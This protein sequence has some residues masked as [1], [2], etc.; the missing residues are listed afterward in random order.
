M[1]IDPLD[2][3]VA[4]MADELIAFRRDLHRHPELSWHEERTTEKLLER[5]KAAGLDPA[6]APTGTGVVCDLDTG[7]APDAPMVVLR[8]DIDALPLTDAKDVPYHSVNSGVCHACGHDVHTAAVLGAGL[9]LRAVSLS[10][11]VRLLFQPAEETLP[12][13]AH[14]LQQA[15]CT[16]GATAVLGL[17][18]A[19]MHEVGT[20]GLSPGPITSAADMI[21]ITLRGPGGHTG[22]PHRTADLVHLAARVVVDL[23]VGLGRLT[24]SRDGINVTFG[25]INAGHA[26]NVIPTEAQIHGTVR[27]LGRDTWERVPAL[28]PH[29]LRAIVEPFG[30]TFELEYQQGSPPVDND[31]ALTAL[32]AG[33]AAQILGPEAVLPTEQSG[34]GEDFSWFQLD[35]P[36]CYVRLGVRSPGAPFVDIHHPNFDVDPAS[37]ALGARLLARSARAVLS[38]PRR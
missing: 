25:S 37:I 24:D 23:P 21:H 5:L 30:A 33:V 27:A 35:A 4:G 32:V 9:A 26:P 3:A 38:A 12:S 16:R 10:G 29:L 20:I 13:G 14:R 1:N 15:G 31:P 2:A 34:G 8:A 36:C 28:V 17:H 19:P 18:C 22:R 6:P 11:R 7:A